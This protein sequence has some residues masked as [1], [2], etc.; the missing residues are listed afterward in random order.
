MLEAVACG[1]PVPVL[2]TPVGA[3]PD[4]TQDGETGFIMEN[5][6]PGCIARNVDAGA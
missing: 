1:K 6:S 3:I 2:A 5:N 4:V